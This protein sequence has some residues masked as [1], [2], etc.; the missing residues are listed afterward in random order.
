MLSESSTV[1]FIL[2]NK[3]YLRTN[4]ACVIRSSALDNIELTSTV[5]LLSPSEEECQLNL[6]GEAPWNHIEELVL[7]ELSYTAY[8]QVFTPIRLHNL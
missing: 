3:I 4:K 5:V 2:W 6:Y 7:M 8:V 1:F